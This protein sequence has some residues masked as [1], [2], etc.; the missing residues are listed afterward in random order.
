MQ[1]EVEIEM[2]IEQQYGSIFY[3]LAIKTRLNTILYSFKEHAQNV[4][5]WFSTRQIFV[6]A[7]QHV[8]LTLELF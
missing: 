4:K 6:L 8:G 1:I 2:N 5:F 7:Q 3:K